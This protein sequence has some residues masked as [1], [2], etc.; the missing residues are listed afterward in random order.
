MRGFMG[1]AFCLRHRMQHFME[2]YI[3]YMMF[4]VRHPLTPTPT[5]SAP[6]ALRHE[7]RFRLPLAPHPMEE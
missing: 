5:P 1:T 4:E 6:L 7:H 3:Y 2:N